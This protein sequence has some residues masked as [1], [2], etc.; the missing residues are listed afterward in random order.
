MK[1]EKKQNKLNT[2][3]KVILKLWKASLSDKIK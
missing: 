1:S 2:L 3:F